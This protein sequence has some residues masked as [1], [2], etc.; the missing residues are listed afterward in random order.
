VSRAA[1]K[2]RRGKRR[3]GMNPELLGLVEELRDSGNAW[4]QIA[5][6]VRQRYRVNALVAMRL[7]RG[8]SQ[9]DAADAWCARWPDELKTFKN[10]SY[11]ELFPSP[12]GYAPSLAVL[13]R[14]AEL[15]ECSV[16]DLLADWPSFRHCDR[17]HVGDRLDDG[18]V[19]LAL[20]QQCPH[21]CTVLSYAVQPRTEGHPAG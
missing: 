16:L 7:A 10:F 9:R 14:L 6:V 1:G 18:V 20:G 8:W 11:W 19:Q 15:Y 21:G 4:W 2:R 3:R 5:D 12:T 13:V 17:I